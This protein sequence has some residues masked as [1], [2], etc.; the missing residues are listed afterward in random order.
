VQAVA[1]SILDAPVVVPAPGEYVADGAARQAAWVLSG[2][3]EP[4]EW[5]TSSVVQR[6]DGDPTPDVRASYGA[7][8]DATA[9]PSW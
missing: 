2:E 5:D 1:A 9:G 7:V 3:V 6:V 4:P 8:R